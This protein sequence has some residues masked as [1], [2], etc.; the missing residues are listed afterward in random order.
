MSYPNFSYESLVARMNADIVKFIGGN[1]D[2]YVIPIDL[3]LLITS[4]KSILN[5]M[6][7]NSGIIPSS[8]FNYHHIIMN[9]DISDDAKNN[10]W[11]L[12]T[13]LF[14]TMLCGV[15]ITMTIAN[16]SIFEYSI[17]IFGSMNATSDI[18]VGVTYTGANKMNRVDEVIKLFEDFSISV[19]GINTLMLDIEMYAGLLTIDCDKTN[20]T[21]YFINTNLIKQFHDESNSDIRTWILAS[22]LRSQVI[23]IRDKTTN[24]SVMTTFSDLNEII[25]HNFGDI[26]SFNET[27]YN[28]ARKLVEEYAK[29]DYDAMRNKYYNNVKETIGIISKMRSICEKYNNNEQPTSTDI[30]NVIV[31]SAKSDFYRAESYVMAPS[32]IHVVRLLQGNSSVNANCLLNVKGNP[33]YIKKYDVSFPKFPICAMDRTGFTISALEQLGF[34][35]RFN[36]DEFVEKYKKYEKRFDDAM[37]RIGKKPT[38]SGGKKTRN[39]RKKTKI[40]SNIK[41]STKRRLRRKTK[42]R[43]HRLTR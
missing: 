13:K 10:L 41:H 19:I 12:R 38:H 31:S 17:G 4:C 36:S 37:G 28:K 6:I 15:G 35:I 27:E 18:D 9:S 34:M 24:L 16:I 25:L 29:I 8:T 2:K 33:E 21:R 3:S 43:L 1:T 23:G 22:M 32:V 42:R 11:I 30:V 5:E 40:R 14:Y 7:A 26:I 20:G 39:V